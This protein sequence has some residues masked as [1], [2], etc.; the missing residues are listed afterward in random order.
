MEF[1]YLFLILLI[2]S[3]LPALV[4]LTKRFAA[5]MTAIK[6]LEAKG[7]TVKKNVKLWFTSGLDRRDC[8]LQLVGKSAV[9]SLK[10]IGFYSRRVS[11]HFESDEC[12]SI[13]DGKEN[14]KKENGGYKTKAKPRYDFDA[15]L[16]DAEKLLQRRR[17]VLMAERVPELI[18]ATKSGAKKRLRIGDSFGEGEIY[19]V[20]HFLKLF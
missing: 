18:T 14:K 9:Y 3:S 7:Y 4:I 15:G 16:S 19:D 13:L 1:L 12:Y 11:L 6:K 20:F 8:E 5:I 10:I 2:F 17:I